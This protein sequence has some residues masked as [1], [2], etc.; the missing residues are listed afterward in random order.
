MSAQPHPS[1]ESP[2]PSRLLR[3]DEACGRFEAAWQAGQ[4]P[5]IEDYLDAAA[6]PD[7]PQLLRELLAIELAYRRGQGETLWL[8]GYRQRFPAHDELLA[9]V[10][11]AAGG[12]VGPPTGEAESSPPSMS[13]GRAGSGRGG[14]TAGSSRPLPD[15]GK[16]RLGRLWGRLPGLRRRAAAGRGHQGASPGSGISA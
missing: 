1:S 9:E 15:H 4:R 8:A 12:W 14:G 11:R 10:F 6:E 5:R 2:S 3:V 13:T 7:R 16:A